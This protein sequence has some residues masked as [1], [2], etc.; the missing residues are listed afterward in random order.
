MGKPNRI[1]II[2]NMLIVV[3]FISTMLLLYFFWENPMVE[4]FKFSEII[5]D[6]EESEQIPKINDV[7]RPEQVIINFGTGVYTAVDCNEKDAWNRCILSLKQFLQSESIL[8]EEITKAQYHKIMEFRSIRCEFL[9]DMPLNSFCKQYNIGSFQSLNT[10]EMFSAIG[11]SSG[12]PESIFLYDRQNDKYYRLI[13]KVEQPAFEKLISD[14][15]EGNYITCYPIGTYVGTKNQ[16]VMPLSLMTYIEEIRY[17]PEFTQKQPHLIRETAQTF[18]GESFD[19]V[20]RIAE[21]KG[22][23]V[24]MYG[25][26]Q[27][28]L[29]INA[30]GSLEYKEIENSSGYQQDYF[31]AL[32]SAL[33][34]VASHGDWKYAQ[35]IETTPYVMISKE[36]KKEKKKGYRFIFGMET[37]GEKLYYKNGEPII[38]EII[39]GQVTYYK[40]NMIQIN[41]ED[42]NP[43][44]NQNQKQAFSAV[45]ML[46]KN[47]EFI[48]TILLEEGYEL[49]TEEKGVFET[50][51]DLIKHVETGYIKVT[52][53]TGN[54]GRL[55][56]AWIVIIDDI[57]LY[58]D[59]YDAEPIGYNNSGAA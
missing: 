10:I 51:S 5:M 57:M 1:E 27:K 30:D 7:I 34:F 28:V 56:P 29:T 47:Y 18:F 26:G 43:I 6:A 38:V 52:S 36:I 33:Q 58:F 45:N 2:K 54:G 40:R 17:K 35:G 44:E 53:E 31:E 24:Y 20:R 39:E 46:A 19:F 59:L 37:N 21:S 41:P 3:L 23:I 32:N 13:S 16:T 49:S 22:S 42:L 12:S 9:Y 4:T 11:Y 48:H 25:Y 55:I 50:V 8:V 14:I 15:K